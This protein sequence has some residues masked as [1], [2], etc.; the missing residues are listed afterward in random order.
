MELYTI[1]VNGITFCEPVDK[2]CIEYQLERIRKCPE[3]E[4]KVTEVNGEEVKTA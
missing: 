1:H 3:L 4:Y 2:E